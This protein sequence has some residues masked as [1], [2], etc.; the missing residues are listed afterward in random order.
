MTEGTET[1][2]KTLPIP[3]LRP[4]RFEDYPQI[5]R[6]ESSHG[7]L[8]LRAD[9]WRGLW[10]NNPLWRRLGDKWPIG[11]VLEDATGTV[12]GSL[13][14]IPSL[15]TYLDRELIA[16]TGR[17]WVVTSDYRGVALWLMDE[18]FHQEGVDLFINTTVNSLAVE[19]FSAFGSVRVPLGD[20]DTAAYWITER[21]GFART[22]LRIKAVPLP[23]LLAIPAAALLRLREAFGVR[24]L[25]ALAPSVVVEQANAFDS[26]FDT[27]WAE[28][29][30]KDSNK[31]LGVRDGRT[32]S[33]HFAG[34]MR[35]GQA[36]AFMASRNHLL[37][38]YCVVKRQDHPQSGLVRMRLVDYQ[39]LESEALLSG[40]LRA[41][42]ERCK[43]EGIY[44]L[45]HVGCD[46]PKM[47]LLDRFAPYRRKLA[48]W[49][50]YYKA[51]DPTLDA[52]LRKPEV[53]DPSAFDGDASL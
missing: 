18:Y 46:L 16:A 8:T 14:N 30:R 43:A 33:W 51:V 15:Y 44:T 42:L 39:N 5:E 28:L 20:W 6:L 17:G 11:W 32:L 13:T 40:L 29:V 1:P 12:V 53:W 27:F 10:L 21:R 49:P 35:A 31:L 26:R 45:E 3:L 4:A 7:L 38:A 34:P 36:W 9:D 47:R 2:S 37:R 50:F 25:P 52:D 41:A 22:A 23:D 24:P 48:A 19:P